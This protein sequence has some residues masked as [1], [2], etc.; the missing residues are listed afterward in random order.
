LLNGLPL[1]DGIEYGVFPLRLEFFNGFREG[2]GRAEGGVVVNMAIGLVNFFHFIE[3]TITAMNGIDDYNPIVDSPH[4]HT[5]KIFSNRTNKCSNKTSKSD[6]TRTS[7]N[8]PSNTPTSSNPNLPTTNPHTV[9]SNPRY[10]RNP[11]RKPH[12]SHTVSSLSPHNCI[13]L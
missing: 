8:D 2:F 12:A 7:S 10:S 9:S 3:T 11:Q 6:Y 13:N 1:L 5:F 4:F